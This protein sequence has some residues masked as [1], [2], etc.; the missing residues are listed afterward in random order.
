[1]TVIDAKPEAQSLRTRPVTFEEFLEL[2][3]EDSAEWVDGEVV[4]MSPARL[5]H[6]DVL[7]F[8]L[9]LMDAFVQRYALGWVYF[10]PTVMRLVERPSGREPDILFVARE[11]AGRLRETFVDGP[12]DLV[13]EIVSPESDVR[14]RGDK[15]LE[16]EA[17]GIPEFWLV[18]LIRRYSI[19]YV[20]GDDGRY[21][22]RALD[23][24]G[25]YHSAVLDGF[26]IKE[27]WLWQRPLPQPFELIAETH[28]R[29]STREGALD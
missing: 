9:A 1:M 7:R 27:S 28:V 21:H 4:L 16:Y 24:E 26:R 17:A 3:G 2:A 14:D 12:A 10:A 18:D 29:R 25:W 6:Q 11:H 15:F 20:L 22:P 19:F 5:E 23:A 13:V 8:L